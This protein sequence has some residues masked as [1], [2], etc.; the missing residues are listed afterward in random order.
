M[1]QKK[2]MAFIFMLCLFL[3]PALSYSA[4][5]FGEPAP[6][7]SE[8]DIRGKH[9]SVEMYRGD[10]LVL[11]FWATWCPACVRE[12]ESIKEVYSN[13]PGNFQFVSVSLDRDL[14]RLE[15]F[16]EEAKIEYPVIF[17]GQAWDNELAKLYGIRQ[18]PTYVLINKDGK[19]EDY[20]SWGEQ[21]EWE[22]HK[23]L[24]S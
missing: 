4:P 18:T 12:V 15:K 3:G 22:M 7:F 16:V 6:D 2:W 19:I 5:K 17:K 8:K 9:H 10:Y 24:K 20:G 1:R 21:L 13:R 14:D 11:Y 23:I